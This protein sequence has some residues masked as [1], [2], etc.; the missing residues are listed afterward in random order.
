[1]KYIL[2]KCRFLRMP[3]ETFAK[4]LRLIEPDITKQNTR[5]RDAISAHDRLC[6]TLRFLATG[7]TFRSL[8]YTF[9]VGR[10][11][12][13]K[14]VRET[15]FAIWKRLKGTYM[16]V[17]QTEEEWQNIAEGFF[18][19]WQLP[20]CCGSI[21]GKHIVLQCPANTGSINYNYKGRFSKILMAVAD[22]HYKFIYI[23][24]GHYGSE[25]DGGVFQKCTFGK[26]IINQ[27]INLPKDA[28]LPNSD[29]SFPYYFVADEAFPLRRNI[30]IP[31][32]RKSH[33]HHAGHI[34]IIR[35]SKIQQSRWG[36]DIPIGDDIIESQR[37]KKP[38]SY[39]NTFPGVNDNFTTSN[40]TRINANIEIYT[41]GSGIDGNVGCSY[42]AYVD[43]TETHHQKFKLHPIC[44]VFQAELLAINN[45]IDWSNTTYTNM[46]ISIFTDSLS[47][48]NIIHSCKLHPLAVDIRNKINTSTNN[49]QINWVRSHQGTEGNER[50]DALAKEAALDPNNQYIYDKNS[51]GTL[52]H[53]LWKE[54][55]GKWQTRWNEMNQHITYRF[56]P[57]L[58]QF[59]KISWFTP[60]H[61]TTQFLSDH[62]G[63]RQL[64]GQIHR[65]RFRVT[66]PPAPRARR[67]V[68]NAFGI[69]ASRF[70]IF[71][72]SLNFDENVTLPKIVAASL[73]LH[74]FL[75]TESSTT[76]CPTGFVDTEDSGHSVNL[77]QWRDEQKHLHKCG[78]Q[79]SNTYSC[80]AK[81][82]RDKLAQ[83]LCTEGAVAWQDSC[84]YRGLC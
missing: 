73:V 9:R 50:A 39:F 49:F 15:C 13:T 40:Y 31:Y 81:V 35:K 72:R 66:A 44:T 56:I 83:Y 23:D 71:L 32:P 34:E 4:L 16:K 57:D 75:L 1:M 46:Q 82:L 21:D 65:P 84:I 69:L 38:Y 55:I 20:N 59:L 45:A 26:K 43:R 11:T 2:F 19:R 63:F 58:E 7:E 51:Q 62:G 33:F 54:A 36:K 24:F 29:V 48:L 77:G 17:S 47:A 42:V 41:D 79:G 18:E 30:M 64:S 37:M 10:T 3:I 5:W 12:V 6:L 61:Y 53:L 78:R 14:I 8:S 70:R 80:D 25:S 76:Y 68:E 28:N 52:K 22:A 74:N 27:T 60:D 67:V